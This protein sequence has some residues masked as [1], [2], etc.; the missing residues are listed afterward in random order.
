M[1][2][3]FSADEI[4]EMAGQIE[5]NGANFYRRAAE[6]PI[7]ADAKR[8]LSGLVAWEESHEQK[9]AAMREQAARSGKTVTLPPESEAGLYLQA[10]ADGRVFDVK[11]DP[12]AALGGGES[13]A[14]V[15]RTAI[16]L[17]KESIVFYVGVKEMVPDPAGKDQIDAIIREEMQHIAWLD[18]QLA[19]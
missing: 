9:F 3:P 6:L 13:T 2:I 1:G 17:E 10:M 16:V 11:A 4:Y 12:A 5:R 15:L 7:D 19:E 14:D 18:H 8:L